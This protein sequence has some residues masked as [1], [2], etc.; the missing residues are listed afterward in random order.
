MTFSKEGLLK[1][2]RTLIIIDCFLFHIVLSYSGFFSRQS[3]YLV[4][5]KLFSGQNYGCFLQHT[6]TDSNLHQT[7]NNSKMYNNKRLPKVNCFK[8]SFTYFRAYYLS[9]ELFDIQQAKVQNWLTYEI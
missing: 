9:K 3:L 7:R 4:R 1:S 6:P 2:Y 8:N 5:V